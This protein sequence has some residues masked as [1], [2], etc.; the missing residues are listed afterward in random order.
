M[1]KKLS[2]GDVPAGRSSRSTSSISPNSMPGATPP[3]TTAPALT[4]SR[5][6]SSG[7]QYTEA[8]IRAMVHALKSRNS[9][10][11]GGRQPKGGPWMSEN[12]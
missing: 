12:I 4:K 6:S 5:E 9:N 1:E 3:S 7:G 11:G 8:G 2:N 10:N